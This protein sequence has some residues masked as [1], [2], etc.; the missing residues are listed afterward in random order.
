MHNQDLFKTQI[1]E[2][3]H[4]G[5]DRLSVEVLSYTV[6]PQVVWRVSVPVRLIEGEKI[7][8]DSLL[9]FI[10]KNNGK[11]GRFVKASPDP[12][13]FDIEEEEYVSGLFFYEGGN[14]IDLCS[15]EGVKITFKIA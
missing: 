4:R 9:F 11:E 14:Y 13:F 2:P 7:F 10:N 5:I 1:T 15:V 12:V 6:V 3:R 8:D